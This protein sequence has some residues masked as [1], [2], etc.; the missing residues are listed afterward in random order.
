MRKKVAALFIVIGLLLIGIPM[1]VSRTVPVEIKSVGTLVRMYSHQDEKVHEIPLDDYLI[2]VV[3]AEMPAGFP[4][5]ALK[6]QA[7]AARTYILKRISV[8]GVENP[9]HSGADVCDD[10]RHGQAWISENEMK[11]RW[12]VVDFYLYYNKIKSV[13][14]ATNKIVITYNGKLI[15]PAYHA[16]CGGGGTENSE[17]VWK[18][19]VPYLRSVACV[20]S[21]KNTERT[22]QIPLAEA[23]Q[24]LGI[25][26]NAVPVSTKVSKIAV[27]EKTAA[28]NPKLIKIS[29]KEI[30]T[31]AVRYMLS[32]RSTKFNWKIDDDQLSI[33]TTG[34]GHGVGMCQYGAKELALRGKNYKE[35]LTHYY[36]GV[37]IVEMKTK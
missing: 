15:D 11:K 31:I 33:T 6:A 34:Y 14:N 35:I 32:L 27:V 13:V 21:E 16:S 17:D 1:V 20:G 22:I 25:A 23:E 12:G 30:P 7:V 3:A 28:G 29:G 2:G 8:G 19:K 37:K 5:E 36:T 26:L 24:K 18:F 9:I 10:H 4:T